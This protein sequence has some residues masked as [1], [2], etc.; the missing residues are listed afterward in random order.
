MRQT[1]ISEAD[2]VEGSLTDHILYIHEYHPYRGGDNPDFDDTSSTILDLKDEKRYAIKRFAKEVRRLVEDGIAISIVPP[3][4]PEDPDSG[5]RKVATRIAKAA[6]RMD[7]TE[8]LARTDFVPP[9]STGTRRSRT[10]H[11]DSLE[12]TSRSVIRDEE[13]LLLDDVT[14]TGTSM[15]VGKDLL[16]KAG[17]ASV[18]C[19]AIAKTIS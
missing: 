19:L 6:G 2:E 16:E 1:K 17:A 3:H 14:T 15:E 10:D 18:Q 12:V 7:A 8:C 5:I 13:V 11:L 4:D 9:Q